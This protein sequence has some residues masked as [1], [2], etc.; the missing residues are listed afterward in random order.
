MSPGRASEAYRRAAIEGA[1]PIAIVRMLYAA[2]LRHLDRAASAVAA[3]PRSG[4]DASIARAD[5]IVTELRLALAKEPAPEIAADLA[6]LYL[7]VEDRLRRAL[8]ERRAEPVAEARAV[9]AR[10]ADAWERVGA[11]S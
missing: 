10:L 3:D 5:A 6:G 9:L 1:P 8:R 4:F 7:F 11:P 2:A